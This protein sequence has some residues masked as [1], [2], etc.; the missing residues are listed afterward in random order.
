MKKV[1]ECWRVGNGARLYQSPVPVAGQCGESG[2]EVTR[3][4]MRAE[5][6]KEINMK[7]IAKTNKGSQS[8]S[9]V[10]APA[11]AGKKLSQQVTKLATG[12][13]EW[14]CRNLNIQAGCRNLCRY[15]Y[16]CAMAVRFGRK[17]PATW[18]KAEID[19]KK[20]NRKYRKISGRTMF[21][22]T[23]DIDS[24]NIDDC[25]TVLK[26]MLSVGNEMLVVS[27]PRLDCTT[28]LCE[29]LSAFKP[30]ILFRFTIGSADD[31]VLHAW[32]PGAPKFAERIACL[33]LAYDAGYQTSVSC[34]P[35]LD[36][37]VHD[38]IAAAR[39][40]VTDSI[41][42]GKPNRLRQIV[43]VNRP[44]DKIT[45]NMADSLL[46]VMTDEFIKGLYARYQ[47]DP[48]IRWKDSI[49]KVVGLDRPTEK[50]LD[51]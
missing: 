11:S 4:T 30:L 26:H 36:T 32:E 1:K 6:R 21:P 51:I 16:A 28:R 22:T 47:H 18:G 29:E 5:A 25:V 42:L 12:T 13:G 20:V 45:M 7:T 23:H 43:A 15:C 17:T 49:K 39:P 3:T 44:G 48:M 34:E 9:V 35:M 14:A 10:K 37:K 50:G 2:N 33:K 38:V 19:L 46:A 31:S 8:S 40:F 27:K 41:W 24:G